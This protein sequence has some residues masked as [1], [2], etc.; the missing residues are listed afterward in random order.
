MI[1]KQI[2]LKT[3]DNNNTIIYAVSGEVAS[4]YIEVSFKDESENNINLSGKTV[5]FYAKKPDDTT[6]LNYCSVNTVSNTATLELTSQTLS[7]PG[8]LECEFQIFGNTNVILKIKGMRIFVSE[9]KDFSEAVESV[10]ESDVIT[11]LINDTQKNSDNLG[12]LND[13]TTTEKS[14]VVEAINEIGS[15]T[16]PVSQG[17]TGATSKIAART[18]LEV[19]KKYTLYSNS[20][21]TYSTITLNDSVENYDTICV[22]YF[23]EGIGYSNCYS[24]FLASDHGGYLKNITCPD[25]GNGVCINAKRISLT[26]NTLTFATTTFIRGIYITSGNSSYTS[27]GFSGNYDRRYPQVVKVVGYKY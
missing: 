5:T 18:N 19:M 20:S 4:R 6:I 15:K 22:Y 10:S 13:L 7:V 8:I 12:D 16:V 11:K 9:S 1:T 24:E 27:G 21:G 2:S 17:G 14:S 23:W 3:W 25:D 26:G